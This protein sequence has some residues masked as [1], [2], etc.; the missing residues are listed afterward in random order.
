[1]NENLLQH[2]NTEDDVSLEQYTHFS[3]GISKGIV[4][5]CLKFHH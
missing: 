5:N 2:N 1:M 3:P 4:K